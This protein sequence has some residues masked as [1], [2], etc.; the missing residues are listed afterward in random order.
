MKSK[1]TIRGNAFG[2]KRYSSSY[3]KFGSKK[4]PTYYPWSNTK[5]VL[6]VPSGISGK[7]Y[8][9]VTT[10]GGTSGGKYFTVKR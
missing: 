10:S 9:R 8:V 5:I 3:V 6:K 4:V 7:V 2:S 1:V